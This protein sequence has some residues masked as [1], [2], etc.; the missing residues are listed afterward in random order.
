ME[1]TCL[2]TSLKYAGDQPQMEF[3][4]ITHQYN[5]ESNLLTH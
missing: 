2:Q 1:A 4:I 3:Y 5:Y